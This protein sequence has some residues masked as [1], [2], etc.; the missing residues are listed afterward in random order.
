MQKRLDTITRALSLF[1]LIEILLSR[2]LWVSSDRSFPMVPFLPDLPLEWGPMANLI[3]FVLVCLCLLLLLI[4]PRRQIFLVSFLALLAC[5]ILQDLNRLQLWVY[6]F[7]LFFVCLYFRKNNN[8]L[9]LLQTLQ[10]LVV[11]L[12]FWSGFG[13]FNAYFVEDLFPGF[14]QGLNV[15][16]PEFSVLAYFV[17]AFELMAGI[18]LLIPSWRKFYV[19]SIIIFH[20]LILIIL[21]PVTQNWA[22]VHLPWNILMISLVLWLFE[23]KG[24]R[25][26]GNFKSTIKQFPIFAY[27]LFLVSLVPLWQNLVQKRG[28]L[29][30]DHFSGMAPQGIF[31]F[32]RGDQLCFPPEVQAILV[33]ENLKKLQLEEWAKEELNVWPYPSRKNFIGMAQKL[34]NCLE[35]PE[36]AGLRILYV[37]RWDTK[38]SRLE[39]INCTQMQE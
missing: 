39:D 7:S 2:P 38:Q 16:Q 10:L 35:N 8:T 34:C 12:Y 37:Q 30:F 6:F 29:A 25:A 20:M 15:F 14:V 28:P 1:F 21:G 3:G 11:G 33:G 13:K 27:M 24:T 36:N 31:Y 32:N 5:F 26:F 9:M 18:G 19:P 23:Q 17:A 4:F 22:D